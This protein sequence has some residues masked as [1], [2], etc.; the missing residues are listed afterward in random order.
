MLWV[1]SP[2]AVLLVATAG[3][4]FFDLGCGRFVACGS[5]SKVLAL[6]RTVDERRMGLGLALMSLHFSICRSPARRLKHRP[7]V[8]HS[9][10]GFKAPARFGS[11][12]EERF[13]VLA[14]LARR[15][16]LG[17]GFGANA[18]CGFKLPT[19]HSGCP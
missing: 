17:N 10:V 5:A 4:I 7:Q 8:G 12:T 11:A 13:L 16:T 19:C 3:A 18:S 9:T 2:H 6:Y 14:L 15:L 1:S